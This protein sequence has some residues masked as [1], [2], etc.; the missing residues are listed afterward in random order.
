VDQPVYYLSTQPKSANT[1]RVSTSI[2]LYCLPV[3]FNSRPTL[4]SD[5]KILLC[6]SQAKMV[7]LTT[8]Q[9]RRCKTIPIPF[10]VRS[11]GLW[12]NQSA[13]IYSSTAAGN[14]GARSGWHRSIPHCIA[15][16]CRWNRASMELRS[17]GTF[18]R[19]VRR[20]YWLYMSFWE[21]HHSLQ[22]FPMY[23]MARNI[24]SQIR[25]DQ[26]RMVS[27]TRGIANF[28]MQCCN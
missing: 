4:S 19:L 20:M 27:A 23:K 12:P 26:R 6:F 2:I 10:R 13:W 15:S 3:R 14:Q 8:L 16:L 7:S 1:P 11:V 5:A 22:V 24:S 25:P 28:R 21:C 9:H 18:R 17:E